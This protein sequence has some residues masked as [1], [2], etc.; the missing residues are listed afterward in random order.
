MQRGCRILQT[1]KGKQDDRMHNF[2]MGTAHD[3]KNIVNI[4]LP[5]C[6][7]RYLFYF[8]WPCFFCRNR[9]DSQKFQLHS[10]AHVLAVKPALDQ[11]KITCEASV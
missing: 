9:H 2:S 7:K 4:P 6:G 1:S 11:N 5:E 10:S 3:V 8:P